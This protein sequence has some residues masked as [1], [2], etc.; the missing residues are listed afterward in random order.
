MTLHD[1]DTGETAQKFKAFVFS[2]FGGVVGVILGSLVGGRMG[3]PFAG[4]VIGFIGGWL[5]TYLIVLGMAGRIA[6]AASSIYMPGG[7]S[8]PAD[9][10]YSLAQSFAVRDQFEEA[11]AEYQRCIA[12][13]PEDAEPVLRLARLYRDNLQRHEDA[14]RW[15]KHVCAMPGLPAGTD[16]MATRELIEVYTHRLKQP[17]PALP[18][19]A[20]LAARHPQTP[21]GAWATRELGALKAELNRSDPADR[22]AN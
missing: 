2:G 16:I 22:T 17:A 20:R 14:V 19:L 5:G 12:A 9:R 8:T 3:A 13:Y 6:G 15:F 1:R 11:A 7:S 18:H 21:A 4:M 10:Q